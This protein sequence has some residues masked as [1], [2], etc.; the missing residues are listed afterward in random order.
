MTQLE[1]AKM[2]K[3]RLQTR[4][5]SDKPQYRFSGP[6]EA[7]FWFM[8]RSQCDPDSHVQHDLAPPCETS[9]VYR[10]VDRLESQGRITGEALR[11][12]VKYG[13]AQEPPDMRRG[14]TFNEC[15]HWRRAMGEFA[16]SLDRKGL[17]DDERDG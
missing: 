16:A 2:A 6:E 1:V 5:V 17:L 8:R 12:M 10:M 11:V 13:R 7:W 9:D 14:A 15:L 4:L 3:G